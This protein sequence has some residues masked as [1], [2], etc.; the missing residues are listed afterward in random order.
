MGEKH[1]CASRPRRDIC[2]FLQI[3]GPAC[4]TV[5]DVRD[6]AVASS[7]RIASNSCLADTEVGPPIIAQ[8]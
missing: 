4:L 2:A 5:R 6:Y 7:E 3:F 8:T 1:R